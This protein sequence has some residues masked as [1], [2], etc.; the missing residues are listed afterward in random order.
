MH[1]G[2]NEV[3][4]YTAPITKFPRLKKDTKIHKCTKSDEMSSQ[5]SGVSKGEG[6]GGAFWCS[7]TTLFFSHV[8]SHTFCNALPTK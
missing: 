8:F 7:S 5:F 3:C 2:D 6:G 4:K 1:T